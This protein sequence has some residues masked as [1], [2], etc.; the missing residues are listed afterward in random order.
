MTQ[1]RRLFADGPHGQRQSFF[2]AKDGPTSA[3]HCGACDDCH[4]K[5]MTRPAELAGRKLSGSPTVL[6][7]EPQVPVKPRHTEH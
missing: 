5:P 1:G 3:M 7:F 2:V 6:A 4:S